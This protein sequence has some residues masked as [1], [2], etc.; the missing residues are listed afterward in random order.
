MKQDKKSLHQFG[1]VFAKNQLGMQ[2]SLMKNFM[3]NMDETVLNSNWHVIQIESTIEPGILKVWAMTEQ[4]VMFNVRLQ[5]PKTIYINSKLEKSDPDFKKVTRFV[6]PRNR[7]VHNLYEFE[8]AE[9][10]FLSAYKNIKY[11][12]LMNPNT[13]GIYETKLPAKFKSLI[14]LSAIVRPIKKMIPHGQQAISRLY[15]LQELENIMTDT[16]YLPSARYQRIYIGHS[17][18]GNRHFWGLFM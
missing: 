13:E 16:Q 18:N 7:K 3:H 17:H 15:K 6:L 2:A 11:K 1:S 9:E 5:V 12:H 8:V 14:E 4:G 10:A